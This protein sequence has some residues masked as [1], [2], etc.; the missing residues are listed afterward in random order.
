MSQ[1]DVSVIAH[2]DFTP[3]VPCIWKGCMAPATWLHRATCTVDSPAHRGPWARCPQHHAEMVET[4]ALFPQIACGPCAD[5]GYPR[6]IEVLWER[7]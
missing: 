5:A 4:I 3:T 7:L 2:L 6:I 1:I